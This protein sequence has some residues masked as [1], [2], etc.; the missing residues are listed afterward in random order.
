[1]KYEL[2]LVL[3]GSTTAAQK[4]TTLETIEKMVKVGEGK[5]LKT[6]DWGK[7]ELAYEISGNDSGYFLIFSLELEADRAKA[8]LEKVRL[9]DGIIRHLL[10]KQ[11]SK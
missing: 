6:D 2:A 8:F 1:M 3:P 4:K 11:E 7:I 5:I 9:E 10:I